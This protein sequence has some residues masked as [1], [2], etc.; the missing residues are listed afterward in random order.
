[1]PKT[2]GIDH[3]VL[4]VSDLERSRKFYLEVLGMTVAHEGTG[5]AFL[6]C[7]SQMI[8]LFQVPDAAKL[9]AGIDMNHLAVQTDT[10]TFESVK[11]ELVER[12]IQVTG[13][14][15]DPDCI[16]FSDPDGHRLQIVYP[17]G[18]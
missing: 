13:R 18:H 5:R 16:Y 2:T 4:H 1:M 12:G 3:V 11:S 9:E 14:P 7:G 10:G 15:G 8:A 6:H 17:G